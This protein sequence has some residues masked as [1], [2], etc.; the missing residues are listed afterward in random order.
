[1]II[2]AI[3][4]HSRRKFVSIPAVLHLSDITIIYDCREKLPWNLEGLRMER[5]RLRTADY[6]IRGMEDFVRIER[7]SGVDF[8]QCCGRSR[9]RWILAAK[10]LRTFPYRCVIVE[11]SW[12]ELSKGGWRGQVSPEVVLSSIA[13]WSAEYAPFLLAGDRAGA[14]DCARRFL[15]ACARHRL[16]ELRAFGAALGKEE[17]GRL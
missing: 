15:M 1:M 7:K 16:R 2:P 8:V 5:G 10:R 11:S 13:S 4:V 9:N 6:T 14:E 17:P 3:R 12:Q